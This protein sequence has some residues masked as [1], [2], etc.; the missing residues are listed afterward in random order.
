MNGMVLAQ[1]EGLESVHDH[2][3]NRGCVFHLELVKEQTMSAEASDMPVD[4]LRSDS[5]IP[6]NLS[7]C[8]TADGLHDDLFVEVW[9]LL[10]IGLVECLRAEATFAGLACEPLDTEGV[11]MSLEVANLLVGPWVTGIVV[12]YALRV[13]AE[14][15]SP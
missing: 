8:H 4:G 14:R 11:G 6:S 7:I 2:F 15:R 10:P 5:N 13:R 3:I 12:V 1:L 9:A